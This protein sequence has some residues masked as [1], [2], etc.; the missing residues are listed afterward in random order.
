ML[1]VRGNDIRP[2]AMENAKRSRV[3]QLRDRR[4]RVQSRINDPSPINPA[5][6]WRDQKLD[7]KPKSL[8]ERFEDLFRL[9]ATNK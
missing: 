9:A 1:E 8:N 6:K 4:E 7:E 5:T 3:Q 2:P